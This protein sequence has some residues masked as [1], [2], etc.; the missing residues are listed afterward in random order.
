[1]REMPVTPERIRRRE[2]LRG[3]PLYL[4]TEESF[5][6]GRRSEEIADAALAAGVRVIQVREKDG[7]ARRALAIAEA[8]RKSTARHGGLLIV[9]DRVDIALAVGADGVHL[10]EHDLPVAVARRFVGPDALIGMSITDEAQLVELDP[11]IDY[12]G[13]GAIFPTGT[14]HDAT[15]TGL[16]LLAAARAATGLPIVA[17]GGID[18][19]NASDVIRAGADSV[20]V[21]TAITQASDP[22]VAAADLMRAAEAA[23]AVSHR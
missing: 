5:S 4:V 15:L 1:V 13:V 6:A 9:N 7:T 18:A 8:I 16:R 2:V 17:I 12:L 21:I 22:E 3:S 20:A 14:K 10:G 11:G 23:I 19:Q